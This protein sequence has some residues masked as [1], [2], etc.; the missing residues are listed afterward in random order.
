MKGSSY[1]ESTVLCYIETSIHLYI[2]ME[3]Y[4]TEPRYNEPSI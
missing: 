1:R 4:G 3:K 2:C